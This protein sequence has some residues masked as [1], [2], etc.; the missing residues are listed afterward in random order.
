MPS[1]LALPT[2]ALAIPPPVSPVGF[3]KAVKNARLSD[4][5]PLTTRYP[6]TKKSTEML[7]SVNT[8][9]MPSMTRLTS[10]R[11]RLRARALIGRSR[12]RSWPR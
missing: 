7:S 2:S 9:V 4:R 1:I 11:R 5:P 12:S 10:R 8:A 3:G 6:S